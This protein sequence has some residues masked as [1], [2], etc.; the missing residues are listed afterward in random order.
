MLVERERGTDF[1][2]DLLEDALDCARLAPQDR[3]LCQELVFGIVRW[4]AALDWLIA[5]KTQGRRQLLPVRVILRLGIY[6]LFWLDRIP[7]HAAVSESVELARSND[8]EPQASFVNA[9]LRTFTR[10]IEPTRLALDDLKAREPHLGWSHPAWLVRRWLARWSADDCAR[11][12][13]WNNSPPPTFARVNTLRCDPGTLLEKWRHEGVEYDFVRRDWVRENFLFKLKSHPPLG[14]LESFLTGC[15]YVQDPSTLLA[16]TE[17]APQSGETILD[18]GAAPGGKTTVIAARMN[19]AGRIFAVD[20][21]PARIRLLNDN[22]RRAGINC[23]ETTSDPTTA[24]WIARHGLFHRALVDAP[25]SNTGV[26]RRRVD[27][28]W[29]LTEADLSILRATQL[30]LLTRAAS[31]LKPGG[32]LIYSTCSLEPDENSE[33]VNEFL[34]AHKEF[35]LERERELLPFRDETDGAYVATLRRRGGG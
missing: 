26:L 32:T 35:T 16:V 2:E 24:T 34:S 29:R 12:F 25:C 19:N 20:D 22:C 5:H 21:S 15:F 10:E 31:C 4:Q 11:L 17:L 1:T 6:Q 33:V 9:V 18:L 13:A 23:V 8:L 7:Q 27:L 28:R 14:R 3:A 30:E